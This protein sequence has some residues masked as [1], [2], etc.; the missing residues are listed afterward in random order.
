[1]RNIRIGW[2]KLKN[3]YSKVNTSLTIIISAVLLL[4]LM[5][6]VMFYS[7][8]NFIQRTMERL[9]RVEMNAVYLCIRN[10]LMEAEVTIDNMSWVVNESL[11]EPNWMFIVTR[12]SFLRPIRCAETETPSC[13]CS[14]EKV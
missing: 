8:Q 6:G 2:Q 9:V 3:I 11:N 4:E 12:E 13:R 7:A 10:Q 14:W 1:M 5:T